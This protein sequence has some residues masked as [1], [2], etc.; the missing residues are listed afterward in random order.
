MWRAVSTAAVLLFTPSIALAQNLQGE[1]VGAYVCGQG[2]TALR[3]TISDQAREERADL[4]ARFEFGP[5]P[6]NPDISTGAF[7]MAGARGPAASGQ[8]GPLVTLRGIQWIEQPAG[9]A[10]VN[11]VGWYERTDE[12]ELIHGE[13][14]AQA[15]V[16]NCSAFAVR[17]HRVPTS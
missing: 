10:M 7:E 15:P 8:I 14:Y 5:H 1:W 16:N 2:A 9:Y 4:A 3:L 12:G 6:G 13:V 11:L 17:R